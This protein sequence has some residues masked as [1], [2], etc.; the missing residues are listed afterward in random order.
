MEIK[1]I[2]KCSPFKYPS[3]ILVFFATSQQGDFKEH[4]Q[5]KTSNLSPNHFA[6]V[7]PYNVYSIP[8]NTEIVLG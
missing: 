1:I 4:T 7:R 3:I 2:P 8:Q 5:I 6:W